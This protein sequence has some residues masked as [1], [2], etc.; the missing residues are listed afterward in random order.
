MPDEAEADFVD[1]FPSIPPFYSGC[2]ARRKGGV[3]ARFLA[4][5][6][7]RPVCVAWTGRLGL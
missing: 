2:I 7:A 3:M 4:A 5:I 6:Q 1:W